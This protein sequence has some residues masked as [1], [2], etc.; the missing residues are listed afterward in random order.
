MSTNKLG[1]VLAPVFLALWLLFMPI[2]VQGKKDVC[3]YKLTEA[4][5][6]WEYGSNGRT[7]A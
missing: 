4:K 3:I 6:D 2:T 7:F 1:V 5:M